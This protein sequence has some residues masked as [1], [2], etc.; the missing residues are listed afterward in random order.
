M[1]HNVNNS[2][3]PPYVVV[4]LGKT[5]LSCARFLRSR[6]FDFRVMDSRLNPPNLDQFQ[7]AFPNIELHLGSFEASWLLAAQ[8]LV[9]N[10]GIALATPEIQAALANGVQAVGDVELFCREVHQRANP[11]KIIAI[12]GSNGKSTVTTLMGEMVRAAGLP[13]VVGG[14]IGTPVLE[15]VDEPFEVVVLELSSFQLETT[16]SLKAT[17]ATVLNVS[18]DHMD[19][20]DSLQ[21]YQQTKLTI[22]ENCQ[23]A[24]FNLDD[25]QTNPPT[26][27]NSVGFGVNPPQSEQFGLVQNCLAYGEELL[28]D[29]QRMKI[30]G[31]HNFANALAALALGRAIGLDWAPMEQALSQFGGLPHRCQWLGERDGVCWFNDSKA[32]NVGASLAAIEGIGETLSGQVILIAGGDG[33]GADFS[34]MKPVVSRFVRELIVLGCDG[35]ALATAVGFAE[36][37]HRVETME[38]AVKTAAALARRGDAVLLAPACASLD[39]YSSFEQRGDRFALAF[40]G[41]TAC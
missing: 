16:H 32:T 9:V 3:P 33:K 38:A 5:G 36:R 7:Q 39:M 37:R 8:T 13:V 27:A 6:G 11:P 30:K 4:G 41:L 19:R 23:T 40:Q 35:E 26:T 21:H 17:A 2:A 22:Y 12:T 20:Y 14:N 15:L 34:E 25:A 24:V 18:E 28:M 1:T 29:V 31:L 10:P